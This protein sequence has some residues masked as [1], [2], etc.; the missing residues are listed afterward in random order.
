MTPPEPTNVVLAAGA[1][2][3]IGWACVPHCFGMCGP[4]H[5]A[6]C[7][8]GGKS[9]YKTLSLFN[10][11]RLIGYTLVG[12]A[13]GFM[14]S[15]L[16]NAFP[17]ACCHGAGRRYLFYLLPG[18]TFL[19]IAVQAFLKKPAAGGGGSEGWATKL[20]KKAQKYGPVPCGIASTALPCG[21]LY[22]AFAIAV[23]TSSVLLGAI[24]LFA[25]CLSLTFFL[26]LGIMV[27]TSAGGKLGPI[28]NRIF[29]W[30]A[31]LGGIIYLILFFT[32]GSP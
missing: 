6:V 16:A 11:G 24:L 2:I 26:Q 15:V 25:Y 19:I 5:L 10:L 29:P 8:S 7:L 23:G 18:I 31:L 12:A 28:V 22:A 13:C 17:K 14:G 1:G 21:V 20:F 3:I 32:Q 4:L 9:R 30:L 27:G